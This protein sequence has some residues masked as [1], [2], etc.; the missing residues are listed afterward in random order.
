[1]ACTPRP[2]HRRILTLLTAFAL[3]GLVT[4]R[5]TRPREPRTQIGH[6][7]SQA[8]FNAYRA[9]YD[10]AMSSLPAPDRTQDVRTDF[11]S[12]RV[13]TWAANT[14]CSTLAGSPP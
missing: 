10:E 13:Y 12:V 14:H 4:R 6:W 2:D 9:A 8:G 1:M 5:L 11:G 3:G 7:R